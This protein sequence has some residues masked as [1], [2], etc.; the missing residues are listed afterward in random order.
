MSFVHLGAGID[1]RTASAVIAQSH[2]DGLG[3]LAQVTSD[4]TVHNLVLD[5]QT[6]QIAS[7]IC[8][9]ISVLVTLRNEILKAA[10]EHKLTAERFEQVLK[11]ELLKAGLVN[12]DILSFQGFSAM[13][14]GRERCRFDVKDKLTGNIHA[15]ALMSN[16]SGY[17][18]SKVAG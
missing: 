16:G 11:D 13:A 5:P 6:L 9:V 18:L 2:Q 12:F 17:E 10:K 3:K 8:S 14:D 15:F 7:L 4:D 1:K